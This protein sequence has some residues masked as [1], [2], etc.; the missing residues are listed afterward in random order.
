M[1]VR[2][3]LFA[4]LLTLF[5]CDLPGYG[6]LFRSARGPVPTL[7]PS[8]QAARRMES[9]IALIAEVNVAREQEGIRPLEPKA[10]LIE[11]AS[12]RGA[13]MIERD[14]FEHIDPL[15]GTAEAERLM[16]T[17]GYTGLL[18]EVLF[19]STVEIDELPAAAVTAWLDSEENRSTLLEPQY[20]YTGAAVVKHERWWYVIQ[21]FAE[22][23]P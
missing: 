10:D 17:Q 7:P 19:A 21:V 9:A 23:G 12:Q 18:G 5:A 14:Y 3:A 11:V 6:L 13:D 1:S 16:R 8:V 22:R 20:R 2:L 4:I 15:S